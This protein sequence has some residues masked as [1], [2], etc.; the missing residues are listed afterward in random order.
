VRH[1]I[2]QLPLTHGWVPV[3]VQLLTAAI[4]LCAIGWRSFHWRLLA[5]PTMAVA[6]LVLTGC[7]YVYI[8]SLGIAGDPAPRGVWIWIGVGGLA[9]GVTVIGW[10]GARWWRRGAS[11]AAVPLCL[12]CAALA[13]N[14]W[15]G[16]FPDGAR[17]LESADRGP[18]T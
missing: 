6:G 2:S 8:G 13:V 1:F 5:V 9:A 15:V 10:R 14:V 17:G 7:A 4:V 18:A 11:V 3:S 16:Y 12:L